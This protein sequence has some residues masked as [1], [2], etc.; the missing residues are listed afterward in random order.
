[1]QPKSRKGPSWADA[2]E[3]P[4]DA[5]ILTKKGGRQSKPDEEKSQP[6]EEE[7]PE[8]LSDMEWMRRRMR[9][10]V[11]AAVP[12]KAFEQSDDED[13]GVEDAPVPEQKEEERPDPT[14][15]TILQTA[16]LFVRNLAFA[17]TEDELRELF[18]PFGE[19]SQ[20]RCRY[21]F[22]FHPS[23]FVWRGQLRDEIKNRDNRLERMLIYSG[24]T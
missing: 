1:M 12:E 21:L 20:V 9:Q 7:P 23:W 3:A 5:S 2:P 24:N 4:E 16:R 10:D 6:V 11:E 15:E 18:Q 19:I 22:S 17:C 8:G 14:K 13:M